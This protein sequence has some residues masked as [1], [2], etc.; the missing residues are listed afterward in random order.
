MMAAMVI[1]TPAELCTEIEAGVRELDAG[2]GEDLDMEAL[3]RQARE[4][5]AGRP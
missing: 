3:L 1:E 5:H 4:E 2:L